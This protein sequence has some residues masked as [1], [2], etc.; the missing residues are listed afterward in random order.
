MVSLPCDGAPV[1]P[2]ELG[3]NM[4]GIER[5]PFAA[6]DKVVTSDTSVADV[7]EVEDVEDEEDDWRRSWFCKRCDDDVSVKDDVD[8]RDSDSGEE[9]NA[10]EPDDGALVE[11]EQ[12]SLRFSL[13]GLRIIKLTMA[14]EPDIEIKATS[15]ICLGM[16]PA[17][18]QRNVHVPATESLRVMRA[19]WGDPSAEGT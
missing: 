4:S 12:L 9:K 13:I 16:A 8:V 3:V 7:E 1:C 10:K 6:S 14:L 15:G 19:D 2:L 17:P 11:T 18:L 5:V